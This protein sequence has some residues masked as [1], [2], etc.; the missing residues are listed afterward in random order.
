MVVEDSL[1]TYRRIGGYERDLVDEGASEAL[2]ALTHGH[3]VT[4]ASVLVPNPVIG[5]HLDDADEPF[6]NH[7]VTS[8]GSMT[9][10]ATYC[11]VIVSY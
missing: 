10:V 3:R 8:S 5:D 4:S 11:P 2:T 1:C 6:R 7:A 9:Y